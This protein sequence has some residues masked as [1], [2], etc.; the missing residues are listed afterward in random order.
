MAENKAALVEDLTNFASMAVTFD[1]SNEISAA[2]YYYEEVIKIIAHLRLPQYEAKAK[3]YQLRA[4]SLR[5]EL[6]HR[7]QSR[8][9]ASKSKCLELERANFLLLQGLEHDQEGLSEDAV[10]HYSDA[11]EVCIKAKDQTEDKDLQKKLTDLATLALDRAEKLKEGITNANKSPSPARHKRTEP[12]KRVIPPLGFELLGLKDPPAPPSESPG[13]SASTSSGRGAGGYT[14]EEKKVLS[15][16]SMINGREYVPFMSV[17]LKEK[18]AF[19]MPFSDKHGKLLLAP[20]Q[21]AKLV[22]WARPDTC[23]ITVDLQA[24][25]NSLA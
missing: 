24:Y 25:Q 5:E 1:K 17:D 11:V 8:A 14:E 13:I 7:E 16:T 22:E 3:E 9:L 10:K 2:I 6:Q 12:P 18:F 19:P 20:K 23:T 15:T 4:S 21:R